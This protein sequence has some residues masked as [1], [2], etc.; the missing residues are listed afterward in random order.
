MLRDSHVPPT[1]VLFWKN[2]CLLLR[3]EHIQKDQIKKK[4]YLF[5]VIG[6]TQERVA[7]FFLCCLPVIYTDVVTAVNLN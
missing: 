5:N 7:A 1:S 2:E 4:N 6:E 3:F